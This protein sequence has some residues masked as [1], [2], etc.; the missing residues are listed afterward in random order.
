MEALNLGQYTTVDKSKGSGALIAWVKIWVAEL[1]N[2]MTLCMSLNLSL[3]SCLISRVGIIGLLLEYIIMSK[4]LRDISKNRN[5]SI[6][7]H[8]Y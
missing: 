2:C 7:V 5:H 6:N 1:T 4:I 3:F 8:L